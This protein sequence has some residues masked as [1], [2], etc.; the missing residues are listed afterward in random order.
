MPTPQGLVQVRYTRISTRWQAEIT[1]PPGLSGTLHWKNLALPLRP[2][3]QT[4]KLP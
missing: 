1:L 4:L 3:L 2:G